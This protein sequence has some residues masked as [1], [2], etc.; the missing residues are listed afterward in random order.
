M[1]KVTTPPP[2]NPPP[3]GATYQVHDA[4]EIKNWWMT[5]HVASRNGL[6]FNINGNISSP[7]GDKNQ[8]RYFT[9]RYNSTGSKVVWSNNAAGLTTPIGSMDVYLSSYYDT[10]SRSVGGTDGMRNFGPKFGW[11]ALTKA[12]IVT[13][14]NDTITLNSVVIN[15]DGSFSADI[16]ITSNDS[17]GGG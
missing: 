5:A 8:L 9:I 16:T 12:G 3:A 13:A 17:G 11:A 4:G 2:N 15:Q 7:W 10:V 6:R 14:S 1:G